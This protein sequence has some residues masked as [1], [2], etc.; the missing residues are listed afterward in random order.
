LI[1]ATVNLLVSPLA[2]VV[3]R[4]AIVA[5]AGC[6]VALRS[7]SHIRMTQLFGSGPTNPKGQYEYQWTGETPNVLLPLFSWLPMKTFN[8]GTP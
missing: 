3:V 6:T 1:K 4:L 2:T 7:A 8:C 5:P